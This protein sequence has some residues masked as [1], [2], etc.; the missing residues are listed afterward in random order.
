MPGRRVPRPPPTGEGGD[1]P[2]VLA[3]I[4]QGLQ[5]VDIIARQIG[6]QLPIDLATLV[7]YG[8][9][10]LLVA[11]RRYDPSYGVPF[12]NWANIRVRG[13]ILDGVRRG[14][15]LPRRVYRIL[16]ALSAGAQ[17]LEGLSEDDAAAPAADAETADARMTTY[18][19]NMATAMAM[20]LLATPDTGGE[21]VD[22]AATPEQNVERAELL[23]K[24]RGAIGELPEAERHI[25]QRH[26][27]D[28][29][30][31]DEAAAEIGLSKSWASRLHARAIESVMRDLKRAKV[32]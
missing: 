25:L 18:L 32:R 28:D 31:I 21:A 7:S 1:S 5:L 24:V 17:L 23:T 30:T 4:R 26:Y 20:G 15:S 9:E 8:R 29:I 13:A 12:A 10:G 6:K 3:R 19:S 22:N 14:G 11:A 16:R 2:E 27:F